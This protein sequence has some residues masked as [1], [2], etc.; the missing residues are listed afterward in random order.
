MRRGRLGGIRVARTYLAENDSLVKR[1]ADA[2]GPANPSTAPPEAVVSTQK[3]SLSGKRVAPASPA[4]DDRSMPPFRVEA[5]GF[6]ATESDIRAVLGSA[7]R[8]L[9]R[10]FPGYQVEP[11]VVTRARGGPTVFYPRNAQGEIVVKLDTERMFWCQYAYQF[12]YWFAKV[13]C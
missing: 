5:E 4:H 6:D 9:W 7:A 2:H 3:T 8:Q 1:I 12:S 13:L 10:H 11:I